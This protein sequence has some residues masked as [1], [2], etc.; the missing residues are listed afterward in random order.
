[1]I[2]GYIKKRL[3]ILTLIIFVIL[4]ATSC[5]FDK[6]DFSFENGTLTINS[7]AVM[8]EDF[9]NNPPPWYNKRDKICKIV[10]SKNVSWIPQYSFVGCN[11]LKSIRIPKNIKAVGAKAFAN[12]KKLENIESPENVQLCTDTF[13]N[14]KWYTNQNE[15]ALYLDKYVVG[16]KGNVG[17]ELKIKNGSKYIIENAFEELDTVSKIIIPDS[18]K[19]VGAFAFYSCKNLKEVEIGKNIKSIDY[20]AFYG[21]DLQRIV[22]KSKYTRIDN[23]AFGDYTNMDSV[24]SKDCVICSL[25]NSTAYK[26]AKKH[27]IKIQILN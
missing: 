24:L 7:D 26:Y 10:F 12:C 20:F 8:R 15:G 18:V 13:A 5:S 6:Q 11:S 23:N 4:I 21:T 25:K 1:M 3:S 14:T 19:S 22:I 9:H 2:S 17:K 27:H 16:H